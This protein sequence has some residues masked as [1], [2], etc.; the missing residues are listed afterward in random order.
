[1]VGTAAAAGSGAQLNLRPSGT[2]DIE[3]LTDCGELDLAIGP[4]VAGRERFVSC[5]LF[6]GDCHGN[7]GWPWLENRARLAV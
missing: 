7:A 1:L 5:H 2:L 6:E 3:D 4:L